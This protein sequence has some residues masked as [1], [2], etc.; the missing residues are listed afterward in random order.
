MQ[1]WVTADNHFDHPAQAARR[2]YSSVEEMNELMV[3]LWNELV[4]PGDLVRVLGDFALSKRPGHFLDRLAGHL[5]L[6]YGNHDK[7]NK[8]VIRH[9]R[10]QSVVPYLEVKH[11]KQLIVMSHYAFETWRN[12]HYGSLHLHGHSHGSLAPRGRRMDVGVDPQGMRPLSLPVAV[13]QLN[14]LPIYQSDYHV[15]KSK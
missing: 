2:G 6:V 13:A 7:E 8:K 5:V 11:N 10:W 1:E 12:S 15:P 4:K 3:K 9:P 14:A